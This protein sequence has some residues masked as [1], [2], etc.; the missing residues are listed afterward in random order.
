MFSEGV[1]WPM[2]V[3]VSDDS[4]EEADSISLL[5][6]ELRVGTDFRGF[7]REEGVN[8]GILQGLIPWLH[9]PCPQV[10]SPLLSVPLKAPRPIITLSSPTCPGLSRLVRSPPL[11]S[12]RDSPHPLR[13]PV[14]APE[15][16][17]LRVPGGR[18]P[19]EEASRKLPGSAQGA[20]PRPLPPPAPAPRPRPAQSPA[21]QSLP[22]RLTLPLP[23]QVESRLKATTRGRRGALEG[24]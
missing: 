24:S 3:R 17:P 19:P 12:A 16:R 9:H 10:C 1:V 21:P 18:R 22:G 2:E 5:K 6:V 8:R 4:P 14:T 7:G 23:R 15:P 20:G 13:A 11:G